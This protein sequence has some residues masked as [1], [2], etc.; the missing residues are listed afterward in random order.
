[1]KRLTEKD[2]QGNW[3]LKG[4]RWEQLRTGQVITEDVAEKLY[5]ALFKLMAYE[6][7]G[8]Y[9]DGVEM[10]M[11]KYAEAVA[12][13]NVPAHEWIPV[14]EKIPEEEKI[15]LVTCQT[16]KGN[17]FVNRAYYVNGFW[18][19]SGSMA[20]VIAWMPLPEPYNTKEEEEAH[21]GTD[22]KNHYRGRFEKIE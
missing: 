20:G 22:W 21:N 2:D 18:H 3:C 9:P 6:D 5:S 19:G 12:L 13:L 17:V 15:V 14:K 8:A 16:K 10:L 4:V 1:M 7:T 11:D